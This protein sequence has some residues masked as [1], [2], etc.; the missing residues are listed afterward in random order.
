MTP[1]LNVPVGHGLDFQTTQTPAFPFTGSNVAGFKNYTSEFFLEGN[2]A[3]S[4][5][6]SFNH[7]PGPLPME[8]DYLQV[9]SPAVS[10]S[11]FFSHFSE[12]STMP[13][14]HLQADSAISAA[15]SNGDSPDPAAMPTYMP[16]PNL[17][18]SYGFTDQLNTQLDPD[19]EYDPSLT[20]PAQFPSGASLSTDWP[21]MPNLWQSVN[22]GNPSLSQQPFYIPTEGSSDYN[23]PLKSNMQQPG[24]NM[25]TREKILNVSNLSNTK[26]Q[27]GEM[28]DLSQSQ[29]QLDGYLATRSIYSQV[30]VPSDIAYTLNPPGIGPAHANSANTQQSMAQH[31]TDY[32]GNAPTY[33]SSQDS[34]EHAPW[35][36][37]GAE[38]ELLTLPN[39][40]STLLDPAATHE[41]LGAQAR[42]SNRIH[43]YTDLMSANTSPIVPVSTNSP[44]PDHTQDM[45]YGYPIFD[46]SHADDQSDSDDNTLNQSFHSRTSQK[47]RKGSNR[48]KQPFVTPSAGRRRARDGRHNPVHNLSNSLR[49]VR[50][51]SV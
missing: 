4:L 48:S 9:D 11:D 18:E 3:V 30:I 27:Y 6:R 46:Y 47:A 37:P 32:V 5:A 13:S 15:H 7:S 28:Y 10:P 34:S 14:N 19:I 50:L 12:T 44:M 2:S 42:S 26:P 8:S 33:M 24:Y 39:M 16:M 38:T 29:C 43:A 40:G 21:D 49:Q 20:D 1:S 36:H 51:T 22:F 41:G 45:Q 25:A 31:A 23:Q 17:S 35:A